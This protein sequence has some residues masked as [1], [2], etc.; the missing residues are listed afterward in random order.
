MPATNI[1]SACRIANIAVNDAMILPYDAIQ[2]GWNFRKGQVRSITFFGNI[3]VLDHG[4]LSIACS[5]TRRRQPR[6]SGKEKAAN[7]GRPSTLESLAPVTRDDAAVRT[8]GR[9]P[10]P[11]LANRL[12]PGKSS[13]GCGQ[14]RKAGAEDDCR[15]KYDLFALDIV[16]SPSFCCVCVYASFAPLEIGR[17]ISL[18]Q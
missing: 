11:A 4:F 10:C 6:F 12:L 8:I 16:Q 13:I 1:P 7:R 5:L 14:R 18:R 17:V 15:G 2:A 3:K 9:D